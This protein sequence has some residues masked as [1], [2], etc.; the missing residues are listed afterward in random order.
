M[1]DQVVPVAYLCLGYVRELYTE[2]EL[3]A[4]GWRNRLNVEE[5][6]FANRWGKPR[7]DTGL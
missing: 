3:Q 5:L 7:S 2:P 4:R 6:F 1:P